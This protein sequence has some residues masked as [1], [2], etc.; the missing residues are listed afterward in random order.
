[1]CPVFPCVEPQSLTLGGQA[2]SL[3]Q[4]CSVS[5]TGDRAGYLRP[6]LALPWA[7]CTGTI[8]SCVCSSRLEQGVIL[9]SLAA[10]TS[11]FPPLCTKLLWGTLSLLWY[12]EYQACQLLCCLVEKNV[13]VPSFPCRTLS[14]W[15][16]EFDKWAP[17]VVKVSYKVR[18][19]RHRHGQGGQRSTERQTP[20]CV[21]DTRLPPRPGAYLMH[22]WCC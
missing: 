15:A 3:Q 22:M 6:V 14:N 18:H 17:S 21:R 1:M 12:S 8:S 7:S 5:H 19:R 16:Y 9:F 2:Q 10:A 4:I 20:V 11:P 13:T